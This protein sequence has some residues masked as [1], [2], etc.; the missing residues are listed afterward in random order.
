MA[1]QYLIRREHAGSWSKAR[2]LPETPHESPMTSPIGHY[3]SRRPS[4]STSDRFGTFH[5]RTSTTSHENG[6]RTPSQP[7]SAKGTLDSARSMDW[8]HSLR[9]RLGALKATVPL[10][11][12]F[13]SQ[14]DEEIEGGEAV[15]RE[16]LVGLVRYL[17]QTEGMPCNGNHVD[18]GT[19]VGNSFAPSLGS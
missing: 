1:L 12:V 17:P 18:G 4:V 3:H 6:Q 11:R 15:T 13:E 9:S 19:N 5:T 2:S 10:A 7:S 8:M 14:I 16:R